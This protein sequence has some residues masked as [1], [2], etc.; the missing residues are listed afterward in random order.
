MEVNVNTISKVALFCF[1]D[2][3]EF[4]NIYK[5]SFLILGKTLANVLLWRSVG[6]DV[7]YNAM[8]MILGGYRCGHIYAK[9]IEGEVT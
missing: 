9:H 2:G 6:E 1:I 3:F 4:L 7:T 8:V 5:I